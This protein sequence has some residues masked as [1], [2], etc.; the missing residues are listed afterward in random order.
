[1]HSN[2]KPT[3]AGAA[4]PAL[5]LD[6]RRLTA[7]C[8]RMKNRC[9][10][11]GTRLRPH[12]KTLKSIDAARYA[13]D[14]SHRGIAVATLNEAEYFSKRGLTDIQCAVCISP[15]KLP[16]AVDIL[17]GA[18]RFSFFVDSMQTA[19]RVVEVAR[20]RSSPMRVWLE[21]DSGEHRTGVAPEH[22]SMLQI[23]RVLNQPPVVFEGVATHAGH[24]YR[25]KKPEQ[26]CEIA[27]Q[28]RLAVVRGAQK[29]RAAGVPVGGVSVGSTPTAMHLSNTEGI[30]EVRAGVYMAGDLFQVALGSLRLE[31]VAVTVLATV[32]SHNPALNQIVV[33]AGA[34]ALSKDRSTAA[35][36]GPDM[37]YGLVLDLLGRCLA[38]DLTIIDVHQ[39]HGEIR[40]N[41]RLPFERLPIGSKVRILPNHVCM[42]A[43]MYEHYL[44]VDGSD[45]VEDIWERTN[46]WS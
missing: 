9:H 28:E 23:A 29:L 18:P 2:P 43:A 24:S 45:T 44:V 20:S 5:V 11:L 1:M 22:T 10:G 7:N 13:I 42:T 41:S 30:T 16:R 37:G 21:I 12:M 34:L 26:L 46:G 27:E 39:E 8:E 14:P 3:L 33:D 17:K 32:I 35:G 15:D 4:T 19:Q 25:A 6:L 38:S 31:E 40:S 36:P